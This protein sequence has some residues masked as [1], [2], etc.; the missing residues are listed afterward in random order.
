MSKELI[1]FE[2]DTLTMKRKFYLLMELLISNQTTS[3]T[4]SILFMGIFYLQLISGFFAKQIEVFDTSSTSD[5]ILNY[6]EKIVRLKDLFLDNYSA[7]KLSIY[8]LFGLVIVFS[9]FFII[10]CYNT[11]KNSFYTWSEILLNFYIKVYIYIGFNIILDLT[12][13]NLCFE[14]DDKNLNFYLL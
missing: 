8:F 6:I 1:L 4:E 9:L 2:K 14:K 12:L 5:K 7:F 3:R 10:V 13:T 11:E